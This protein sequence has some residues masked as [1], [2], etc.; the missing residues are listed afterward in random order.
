MARCLGALQNCDPVFQ[1]VYAISS[2]RADAYP[3]LQANAAQL[4]N[5]FEQGRNREDAPPRKVIEQLGYSASFISKDRSPDQKWVIRSTAGIYADN[6]GLLNHF[7]LNLPKTGDSAAR[8]LQLP[9]A[10]N[11]M[12]AVISAWQPEWATL[13]SSEFRTSFSATLEIPGPAL[14]GWMTYFSRR[15]GLVPS[16]TVHSRRE[17]PEL[18]TLLVVTEN[19]AS[20][21]SPNDLRAAQA[22]LAQLRQAKVIPA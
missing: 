5:V 12:Q 13:Q 19:P 14:I 11:L 3:R 17:L 6:P 9:T 10:A 20:P 8:L 18:G 2:S 15:A 1:D 16:V 7:V 21:A 22:L 4:A